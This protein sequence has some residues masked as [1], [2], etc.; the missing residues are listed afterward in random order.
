[1]FVGVDAFA[2]VN[3]PKG[4]FLMEYLGELLDN[5]TS[6]ENYDETGCGSFMF[7]FKSRT[8]ETMWW[9]SIFIF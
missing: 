1:M 3:I 2:K 8:G 6:A 4:R 9:E 5:A 7:Y